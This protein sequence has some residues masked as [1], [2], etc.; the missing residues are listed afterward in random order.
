MVAGKLNLRTNIWDWRTN[1]GDL[2]TNIN[3]EQMWSEEQLFFGRT[4]ILDLKN[5]I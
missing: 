4:Y 1:I 5:K 3:E 2:R